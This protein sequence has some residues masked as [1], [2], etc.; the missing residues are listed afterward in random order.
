MSDVQLKKSKEEVDKEDRIGAIEDIIAYLAPYEIGEE[1]PM[2]EMLE[3]L[4]LATEVVR[5]RNEIKKAYT[6]S[7]YVSV[8][9]QKEN[10]RGTAL[11]RVSD[12]ISL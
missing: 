12:P 10:F 11:V 1:V 9:R 6:S 7:G 5:L 4:G 2:K 8:R 3:H